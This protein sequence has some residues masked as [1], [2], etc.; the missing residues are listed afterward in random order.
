MEDIDNEINKTEQEELSKY[1]EDNDLEN[2]S[3]E[4]IKEHKYYNDNFIC[5][6]FQ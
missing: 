2:F 6:F 5:Y 1:A 3:E 4:E